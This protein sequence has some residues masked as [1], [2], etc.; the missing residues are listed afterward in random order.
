[1]DYLA[2]AHLQR[3]EDEAEEAVGRRLDAL[4]GPYQVHLASTYTL[5]AVPARLALE[6]QRWTEAA[7]LEPRRPADYPWDQTPAME[8]I[9]HFARA[10]GAARSG[11]PEK[12][13]ASVEKLASLR[14]A[15][16][17]TSQYWADQVAIQHLTALAWTE[18]AE[19]DREA[20]LATLRKAAEREAATEKHPVT[21]GEVLPAVELLGDMLVEMDRPSEAL[22]AYEAALE[23]SPGRFNSLYGAG[24]AAE[25]AGDGE[26]AAKYYQ[27][28]IDGSGEAAAARDRYAHARSYLEGGGS[29][30]GE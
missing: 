23:R 10:L 1:L 20:G 15:A 21:P 17:G 12:A 16:A 14:D 28:L 2:Y 29:E 19:G 8:A 6:R 3:G 18:Y 13:R 11:E 26:M 7:A 4:E 9:T 24:R 27:E 22:I 5:A 30:P 25:Q